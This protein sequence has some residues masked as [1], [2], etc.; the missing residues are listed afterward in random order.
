[1]VDI[2]LFDEP[3]RVHYTRK[4]KNEDDNEIDGNKMK[5]EKEIEEQNEEEFDDTPSEQPGGLVGL[6][7]NLSGVILRFFFFFNQK[8]F[9][10]FHWYSFQGEGSDIA[11]V[12]GKILMFYFIEKYF[13]NKIQLV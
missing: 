2:E 12:L 11:A 1:M 7:T 9:E 4:D 5:G 10:I 8:V 3:N 13:T 6:I